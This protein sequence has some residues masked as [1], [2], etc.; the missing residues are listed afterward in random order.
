MT[1]GN[2]LSTGWID[3]FQEAVKWKPILPLLRKA[4]ETTD[5]ADKLVAIR[6]VAAFFLKT[7]YNKDPYQGPAFITFAL[8]VELAQTDKRV[9]DTIKRLLPPE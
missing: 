3:D 7:M 1:Q 4:R 5:P 2:E 6:E 9:L 8:L